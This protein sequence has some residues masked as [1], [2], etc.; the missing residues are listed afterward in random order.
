MGKSSRFLLARATRI[1]SQKK[2]GITRA[3]NQDQQ[4]GLTEV[5]LGSFT[6]LGDRLRTK[7]QNVTAGL[8]E[9]SASQQTRRQ[10]L[11]SKS[12]PD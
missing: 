10:L 1:E 2:I 3:R 7:E 8:K 12:A 9:C 4:V 11:I 6:F 5:A